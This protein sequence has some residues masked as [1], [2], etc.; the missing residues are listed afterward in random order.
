MPTRGPRETCAMAG[1]TEAGPTSPEGRKEKGMSSRERPGL[2]RGE[3][4]LPQ[5][6]PSGAVGRPGGKAWIGEREGHAHGA[7]EGRLVPEPRAL[8]ERPV[9]ATGKK[10]RDRSSDILSSS[11]TRPRA[12]AQVR[13]RPTA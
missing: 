1:T 11:R 5:G 2:D 3:G 7:R 4:T 9:H 8:T 12:G 13:R 6:E 10:R